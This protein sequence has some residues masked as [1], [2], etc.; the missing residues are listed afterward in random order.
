MKPLSIT[1]R[2]RVLAELALMETAGFPAQRA[3]ETL[4]FSSEPALSAACELMLGAL[5]R[6][7]PLATAGQQAG[8]FSA[9][10]AALVAA[11]SEGGQLE[12][13]YRR[14]AQRYLDFAN[15]R[16]RVLSQL[17]LPLAVMAL[18]IFISPLPAL[19]RD[20]LSLTDYVLGGVWQLGLLGVALRL[21]LKLL[22]DVV[23]PQPGWA[24]LDFVLWR[25]P[26]LGGLIRQRN[27]ARF[28]ETLGLLLDA[29][30]PALAAV[31]QA[32][33][34]LSNTVARRQ[35]GAVE[36]G[37]QRGM[38]WRGA[39]GMQAVLDGNVQ[40]LLVAGEAAGR[41][42]EMVLRAAAQLREENRRLDAA[43]ATWG[44]RVLYLGVLVMFA[45][46]LVRGA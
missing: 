8:L 29:G 12:A 33:A 32:L 31:K 16:R 19:A 21:G 30:L 25:L 4:A 7:L 10:D 42:P 13:V 9:L 37:L 11:G 40:Q 24:A 22:D 35:L 2:A 15:H 38:T 18:G 28:L 36:Q 5:K 6:G 45:V 3:L 1:L 44:P 20:E 23:N 26:V 34:V 27:A 39:M 43:L 46:G 14:L 41:L 17:A